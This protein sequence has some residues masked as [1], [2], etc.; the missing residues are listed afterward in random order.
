MN[1]HSI[2]SAFGRRL[3]HCHCYLRWSQSRRSRRSRL[4]R[5]AA[6]PACA[7]C[8]RSAHRRPIGWEILH[9]LENGPLIVDLPLKIV[10]Y[11]WM[12]WHITTQQ[13]K[14]AGSEIPELAMEVWFAGKN[15][16]TVAGGFS[17]KPWSWLPEDPLKHHHLK[18]GIDRD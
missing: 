17:S 3:R 6:A 11:H 12:I 5:S 14:V 10:I 15:H 16:R 13:S 2:Q 4:S 9:F 18:M 1:K 7:A 8:A